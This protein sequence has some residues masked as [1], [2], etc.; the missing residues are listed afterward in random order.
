MITVKDDVLSPIKVKMGTLQLS[1]C[2]H[3]RLSSTISQSNSTYDD[4]TEHVTV[5]TSYMYADTRLCRVNLV[6]RELWFFG[7]RV[8][9]Q[10]TLR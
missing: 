6:P 9:A 3:R 7:Q 5:M 4:E 10:K 1:L 2:F 8:S